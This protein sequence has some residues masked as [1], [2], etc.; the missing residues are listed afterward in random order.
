MPTIENTT[1]WNT[2]ELTKFL[3]PLC[4]G[5]QI[6]SIDVSLLLAQPGRKRED[7]ALYNLGG[8]NFY[9]LKE[10]K[11]LTKVNVEIIS[12]KRAAARTDLLDR[13]AQV[14]SLATHEI[15]LP[16][17]IAEG[18]AHAFGRIAF[19]NGGGRMG[20]QWE[21]RH[22]FTSDRHHSC[23]CSKTL[24]TYPVIRGNTK[25]RTAPPVDIAK[26][27]RRGRWALESAEKLREKMEAQLDLAK[28]LGERIVREEAKA[29][30]AMGDKR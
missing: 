14:D 23:T 16:G 4:K 15:S 29:W 9:A 22:H 17:P 3:S 26:L 19:I 27:K 28:R 10:N 18:I 30:K 8:I 1:P 6:E 5:T 21:F 25:T 2:E 13:M 12:P 20:D 11:P 24:S 7:Q